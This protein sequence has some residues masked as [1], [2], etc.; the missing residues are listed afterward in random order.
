M[1]KQLENVTEIMELLIFSGICYSF[2]TTPPP[3]FLIAL[4]KKRC[5]ERLGMKREKTEDT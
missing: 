1:D 3:L 4:V 2:V 5:I